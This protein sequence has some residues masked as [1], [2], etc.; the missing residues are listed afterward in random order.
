MAG[1][2]PTTQAEPE[3]VG[4]RDRIVSAAAEGFARRGYA[5]TGL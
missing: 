4:T 1:M 2:A 5:G 3:V